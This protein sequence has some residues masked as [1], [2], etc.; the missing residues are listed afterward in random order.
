M[1]DPTL[2][3][4][5]A[6]E[7]GWD[8]A[9]SVLASKPEM[10]TGWY[11]RSQKLPAI[12]FTNKNETPLGGGN[13]PYYAT[14]QPTGKGM[15]RISGYV[16]VDCV[17][18]TRGD[19]EGVGTNGEDLNPKQVRHDLYEQATQILTD[20]QQQNDLFS[21]G[22]GQGREVVDTDDGPASY[23]VQWRARYLRDRV[24]TA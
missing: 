7:A 15:N 2:T 17:A 14:H 24:P 8:T 21:L 11:D 16:L 1:T 9:S 19:C 10:Q 20:T 12:T 23:R 5:N 4:L 18:G 22:A 13:N 6:I 3:I